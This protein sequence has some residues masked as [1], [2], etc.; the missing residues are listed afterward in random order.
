[1]ARLCSRAGGC[2]LQ[3]VRR[4]FVSLFMSAFYVMYVFVS[5]CCVRCAMRS[6]HAA[7]TESTCVSALQVSAGA[8]SCDGVSL[9]FL[10]FVLGLV[11]MF[12]CSS[13][14]CACSCGGVSSQFLFSGR[15]FWVWPPS[16]FLRVARDA[17]FCGAIYVNDTLPNF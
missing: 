15:T 5:G 3:R 16:H 1:M 11:V 12:L 4:L 7:S 10:F 6:V 14:F 9:Q 13:G 17:T 2:W 8:L